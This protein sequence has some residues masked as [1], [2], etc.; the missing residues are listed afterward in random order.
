MGW[1]H[2]NC[3]ANGCQSASQLRHPCKRLITAV[4]AKA[5][6]MKLMG[7]ARK[8]VV[9]VSKSTSFTSFG[10]TH[11]VTCLT[12]VMSQVD[13]GTRATG[14][15]EYLAWTL[16]Q[17]LL[18]S[19]LFFPFFHASITKT[20]NGKRGGT[21]MKLNHVP[22]LQAKLPLSSESKSSP[23]WHPLTPPNVP[24]K[25]LYAIGLNASHGLQKGYI[26]NKYNPGGMTEKS[27]GAAPKNWVSPS[28]ISS[29]MV[30]SSYHHNHITWPRKDPSTSFIVWK[31]GSRESH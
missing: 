16:M 11:L 14:T 19:L 9:W 2:S 28:S 27:S 8:E 5:T 10:Q 22:K 31:C 15:P 17:C 1:A 29:R 12:Y 6:T 25:K 21:W 3:T 4:I 26:C 30:N 20:Y 18:F 7:P 23:W 24:H 13:H